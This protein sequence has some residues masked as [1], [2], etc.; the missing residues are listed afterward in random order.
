[1]SLDA[2][3][4]SDTRFT[5]PADARLLEVGDLSPRLQARIGP[6]ERGQVVVSRPGFRVTTR[7]VTP[8]LARLLDQFRE[9][10]RLVD[11]VL[12]FSRAEARDPHAT[13]EDAFDAL[14]TLID[15][16]VLVAADSAEAQ[17]LPPSLAA[18][19]AM[20]SYEIEALVHAVED[21]EV[22]RALAPDGS[23]AALKIA[24]AWAPEALAHE[25]KVL[26][27]LEGVDSPRL[28]EAGEA[29]GR[30]FIAMAWRTGAPVAFAAQQA[31]AAGDRRGLHRMVTALLEAY[32]RLH[33]RGVAHGG[34]H[35]G[36]ILVA[37]DG[38]VTLL[39]FGRARLGATAGVD[40]ARAGIAHFHEPEMAAALLAGQAPPAVTPRAEQYALAALAYL[41]LT[42]LHPVA[43]AAEQR[44]LLARIVA[45]PPLPFVARGVAAWPEAEAVLARALSRDPERRFADVA[46][47]A[48]AFAAARVPRRA[49]PPPA[50]AA[51]LL[52]TALERARQ[53][54]REDG[55]A[56]ALPLAWL[57]LR[58]A[59]HRGD[60]ELLAA[61]DLWAG[62]AGDGWATA[63]VRAEVARAGSDRSAERL[64][65]AEFIA[66]A[67]RSEGV[68]PLLA[69][70]RLLDGA[71][72]REVDAGPLAAWAA[73]RLDR[74]WR[75]G[76]TVDVLHAALALSR[77]GAVLPPE[78]LRDRL[79]A[80]PP[81]AGDIWLWA[82]AH[83]VFADPR[84]AE[85]ALAIGAVLADGPARLRLY[86]ITGDR[87]WL[88]AARRTAQAAARRPA[89][90][91]ERLP[92][93]L[94]LAELERPE[95]AVK[96]PFPLG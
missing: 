49:P 61:A 12:R 91:P 75:T 92:T 18:G 17:G 22:Y 27:R 24:R 19:Q 11:A 59:I 23:A 4:L 56:D 14:A 9:P 82:L 13:L 70:A 2:G 53:G 55:A 30:A 41:M 39:D 20:A 16:R 40:P 42:G 90:A 54:W 50:G 26:A 84:D 8:E 96:P 48:A 93:A 3:G 1:M 52:E 5:L 10:S 66:A 94:L 81:G 68:A 77:S 76:P 89:A 72:D 78:G 25:A 85:R 47:F 32:G 51:A 88:S 34:I 62:R 57:A 80:L 95:W 58:A 67:D 44:E 38:E 43:P 36:N 63:A 28:L 65:V 6:I 64:A 79:D 45:R 15:G 74:A 33:A 46:A 37:D 86:Q 83:D 29:E 87:R 69:A 21:T 73:E 35:P 31:R 71:G 60:P 7:L